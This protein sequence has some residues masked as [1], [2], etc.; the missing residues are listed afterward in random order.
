MEDVSSLDQFSGSLATVGNTLKGSFWIGEQKLLVTLGLCKSHKEQT[1]S[2]KVQ[3]VI[4]NIPFLLFPIYKVLGFSPLA[5]YGLGA[6]PLSCYYMVLGSLLV[7]ISNLLHSRA[8]TVW[9]GGAEAISPTQAK[10][11]HLNV[12]MFPGSLPYHFGKQVPG[13]ERLEVLAEKIKA[14]HPDLVFLCEMGQTFSLPLYERIKDDYHLF[15]VNVGTM[16]SGTDTNLYFVSKMDVEKVDFVESKI[17]RIGDQ[18]WMNRGYLVIETKEMKYV[19][20][21]LHPKESPEAKEVRRRQ[22]EE[23]VLPL[24]REGKKPCLLLGDLNVDRNKEEYKLIMKYFDD[25]MG[26]VTTCQEGDVTESVDYILTLKGDSGLTITKPS[27]D[28]DLNLSDHA[29]I[30]TTV[31]LAKKTK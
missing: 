30:I 2:D 15:V 31:E 22:I 25:H 10:V 24:M 26:N 11:M 1:I 16:P 12:C 13:T 18:K 6:L 21:H 23:E 17:P 14:N 7:G 27:V 28:L 3:G 20:T 19:Y 9:K 4:M 29:S 5:T 8:W